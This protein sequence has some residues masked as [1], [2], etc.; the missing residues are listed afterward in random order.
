MTNERLDYYE[1][2][3]GRR[4]K[5]KIAVTKFMIFDSFK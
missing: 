3:Y 5:N 4:E 1:S 2:T